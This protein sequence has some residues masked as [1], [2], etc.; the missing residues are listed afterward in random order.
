MFN[1]IATARRC[2][3]KFYAHARSD[4]QL[5]AELESL[6]YDDLSTS[7]EKFLEQ[8]ASRQSLKV[9]RRPTLQTSA[10]LVRAIDAWLVSAIDSDGVSDSLRLYDQLHFGREDDDPAL[11]VTNLFDFSSIDK[12]LS[13]H[14]MF[15]RRAP[16]SAASPL[17][18]NNHPL[19]TCLRN[20]RIFPTQ[21]RK[22]S[23]N[24]FDL[25]PSVRRDIR[26][27][28]DRSGLVNIYFGGYANIRGHK[29]MIC[30]EK[31]RS[32][33]R[34]V[35]IFS[36]AGG[37]DIDKRQVELLD[38]LVAARKLDAQFALLPELTIAPECAAMLRAH[39]SRRS[40]VDSGLLIVPGTYHTVASD[41][42]HFVNRAELLSGGRNVPPHPGQKKNL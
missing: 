17:Y 8:L 30:D 28:E 34:D 5:S 11:N 25:N 3:I 1:A 41:P 6:E 33:R 24:V 13:P 40:D 42:G 12:E 9:E 36:P 20:H 22:L 14:W 26:F 21:V 18:R 4:A 35:R 37:L 29:Q 19:Y 16:L 38:H 2:L 23:I 31:S 10:S 15:P 39:L 7:S 32:G 27:V